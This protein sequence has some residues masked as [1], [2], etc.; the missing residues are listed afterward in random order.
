MANALGD[1]AV[2]SIRQ[3]QGKR[4][5]KEHPKAQAEQGVRG[6]GSS[7]P[8]EGSAGTRPRQ[9]EAGFRNVVEKNEIRM[10][11]CFGAKN[12]RIHAQCFHNMYFSVSVLSLSISPVLSRRPHHTISGVFQ[13]SESGGYQAPAQTSV[14]LTRTQNK[15]RSATDI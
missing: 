15:S 3:R 5:R 9:A 4:W 14:T 7:R 12:I 1:D 11:V 8:P 6:T 10:Q 13:S 2:P